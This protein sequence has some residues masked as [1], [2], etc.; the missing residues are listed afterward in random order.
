M[1]SKVSYVRFI[2]HGISPSGIISTD[3]FRTTAWNRDNLTTQS[4]NRIGV[5]RSRSDGREIMDVFDREQSKAR[6]SGMRRRRIICEENHSQIF[7][8]A[9]AADVQQTP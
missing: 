5:D 6:D 9:R 7:S 3:R 8:G 1:R 2:S 4:H